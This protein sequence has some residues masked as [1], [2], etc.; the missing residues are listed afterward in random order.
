[1]PLCPTGCILH[2][3]PMIFDKIPSPLCPTSAHAPHVHTS[4]P[5]GLASTAV[6][7]SDNK[8]VAL[9]RL[10][11]QYANVAGDPHIVDRLTMRASTKQNSR[12]ASPSEPC[13]TC[14]L[15]YHPLLRHA[16]NAALKKVTVPPTL[17]F[18]VRTAW[19]NDL[20][21]VTNIIARHNIRQANQGKEGGNSVCVN[22]PNQRH[23]HLA[24]Q[25]SLSALASN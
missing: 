1:M 16:V 6:A 19:T 10:F 8:E 17:G 25:H 14:V 2:N 18:S 15:K 23:N 13:V 5:S 22:K 20:P 21:S 9:E 12:L 11:F 24:H 4:W 3:N 7:L